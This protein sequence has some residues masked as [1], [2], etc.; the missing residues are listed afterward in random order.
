MEFKAFIIKLLWQIN[1]LQEHEPSS[2]EISQLKKSLQ[3]ELWKYTSRFGKK[4][5]KL[6][7]DTSTL[8]PMKQDF[9]TFP[10]MLFK[11]MTT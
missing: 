7:R 4:F 11:N 9:K 2:H 6:S 8:I 1:I 3:S 10:I 5:V